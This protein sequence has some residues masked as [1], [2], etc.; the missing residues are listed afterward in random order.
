MNSREIVTL[1]HAYAPF[2]SGEAIYA[3]SLVASLRS[4]GCEVV[5]VASDYSHHDLD[6]IG[7]E[8]SYPEVVSPCNRTSPYLQRETGKSVQFRG[9]LFANKFI[10]ARD[11]P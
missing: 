6:V 10:C 4:L 1:T 2:F 8:E 9:P 11:P 3:A 7:A 5:V